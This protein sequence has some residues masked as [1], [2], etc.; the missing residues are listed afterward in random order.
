M[1][2]RSVSIRA[3]RRFGMRK[4]IGAACMMAA[5]LD[6]ATAQRMM[7]PTIKRAAGPFRRAARSPGPVAGFDPGDPYNAA[8]GFNISHSGNNVT[9]KLVRGGKPELLAFEGTFE[10][11]R[12]IT[13]NAFDVL[14]HPENP[15]PTTA[16]ITVLDADRIELGGTQITRATPDRRQY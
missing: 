11:E 12:S 5:M 8:F 16:K 3:G 10:S 1:N 14:A 2:A 6:C 7:R 15:Q 13:G 4:T 9:L